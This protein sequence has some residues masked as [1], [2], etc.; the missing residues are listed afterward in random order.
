MLEGIDVCETCGI[1]AL[2]EYIGDQTQASL[3]A[4]TLNASGI[5]VGPILVEYVLGPQGPS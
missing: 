2:L 4:N 3:W 5:D 1:S